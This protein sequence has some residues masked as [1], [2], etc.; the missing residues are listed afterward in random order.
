MTTTPFSIEANQNLAIANGLMHEKSVRHLPVMR[1][2]VLIGILTDRDL[3]LALGIQGVDPTKTLVQEIAV[4]APFITSPDSPVD[5]VVHHMAEKRIGSA[6]VV[7]NH[8]LV[9]IFTSTDALRILGEVLQERH[10]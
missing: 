1:D 8:K 10:H 2:G 6:L 3:K 7:Q 5:Q 9:G 4:D